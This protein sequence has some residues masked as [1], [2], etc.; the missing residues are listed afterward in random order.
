MID[1]VGRQRGADEADVPITER[2][3]AGRQH[4]EGEVVG[5]FVVGGDA[6]TDA[7]Q[8]GKIGRNRNDAAL[9]RIGTESESRHQQECR[10]DQQ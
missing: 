9:L 7:D 1:E 4:A 3:L 8:I 6:K 2:Q 10:G 5:A